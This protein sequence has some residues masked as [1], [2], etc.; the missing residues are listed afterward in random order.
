MPAQ[1]SFDYAVIRVV[2]HVERQEFINVGVILFCKTLNF[3]DA[4]IDFQL[5]RLKTL[6]PEA[7]LPM[8]KAHLNTIS[9]ICTGGEEAGHYGTLSQAERFHWLVAPSSTIIQTS[10]VHCGLCTDPPKALERLFKLLIA[11]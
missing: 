2:P 7:N 9:L 10:P 11:G 3:L 1:S 8:I 5:T 4:R 6:A